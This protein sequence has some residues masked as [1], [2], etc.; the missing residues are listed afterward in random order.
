[1]IIVKMILVIP[2]TTDIIEVYSVNSDF[3]VYMDAF[4]MKVLTTNN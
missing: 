1:M 2:H 4:S 3:E